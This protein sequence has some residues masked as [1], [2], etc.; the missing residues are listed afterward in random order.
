MK[1]KK[2]LSQRHQQRFAINLDRGAVSIVITFKEGGLCFLVACDPKQP[3]RLAAASA[4]Q[5][6]EDRTNVK[7]EAPVFKSANFKLL[8]AVIRDRG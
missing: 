1:S 2:D 5:R 4:I 8:N 3:G 7:L 6:G